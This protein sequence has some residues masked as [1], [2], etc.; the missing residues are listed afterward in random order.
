MGRTVQLSST[1]PTQESTATLPW[2]EHTIFAM[3]ALF[4]FAF[5]SFLLFKQRKRNKRYEKSFIGF[6]D[7]VNRRFE[8][9][10][11]RPIKQNRQRIDQSTT[12]QRTIL[13]ESIAL[14]ES[15]DNI[16]PVPHE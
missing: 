10:G 8:K 14:D 13:L 16:D 7:K 5:F 6:Y 4:I 1:E 2:W 15:T 9:I 11:E 12:P 3:V